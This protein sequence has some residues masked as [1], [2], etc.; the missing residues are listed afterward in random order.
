MVLVMVP[1]GVGASVDEGVVL[2]MDVDEGEVYTETAGGLA[3]VGADL[4]RGEDRSGSG[5]DGD[6][7]GEGEGERI[8]TEQMEVP[9]SPLQVTMGCRLDGPGELSDFT[10][11]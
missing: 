11:Y 6:R 3:G 1:K 8:N 7:E 9:E 2:R 4:E 10:Y 5:G